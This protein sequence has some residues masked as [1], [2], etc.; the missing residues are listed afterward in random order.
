MFCTKVCGKQKYLRKSARNKARKEFYMFW[1]LNNDNL[2]IPSVILDLTHI[3]TY[4]LPRNRKNHQR[5]ILVELLQASSTNRNAGR[6][7]A[8]Q[9]ES[10]VITP[11]WACI[12]HNEKWCSQFAPRPD[13]DRRPAAWQGARTRIVKTD[14]IKMGRNQQ[15]RTENRLTFIN[16]QIAEERWSLYIK[17]CKA[18]KT[19]VAFFD[20]CFIA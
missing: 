11:V 1:I 16:G 6:L 5:C 8:Y 19:D 13:P 18:R 4:L 17:W 15:Q 9:Q 20:Y 14:K 10:H 12:P 2:N 7:S 3:A